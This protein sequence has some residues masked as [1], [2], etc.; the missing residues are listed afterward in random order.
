MMHECDQPLFLR[1][2]SDETFLPVATGFAERVGAALGLAHGEG[3]ALRLATEEIFAHLCQAVSSADCIEMIGSGGGYF[4]ELAFVFRGR[5]P[6]RAFNL[7]ATVCLDDECGLEEMGLLLASRSVDRFQV[8]K[9]AQGR[10]QL[11]LVKE[12][13]YPPAPAEPLPPLAASASYCLREP[14]G[15]TLKLFSRRVLERYPDQLLPDFFSYPGK[16]VDMVIRGDFQALLAIDDKAQVVG[17]ITWHRATPR[18]IEFFGPYDFAARSFPALKEDLLEAFLMAVGKSDAVGV[19]CRLPAESIPETHFER[20]G[21]LDLYGAERRHGAVPVFFRQIQED[22][23]TAVWAHPDLE[24]FLIA[25]YGRLFLPRRIEPVR[26]MGEAMEKNSVFS[27]RMDRSQQLV[28]LRAI[29]LG[30]DL[31]ENLRDHVRLVRREAFNNL[32]FELDLGVPWQAH[33]VPALLGNGFV[34]RLVVPY[35]G[36]SDLVIYQWNGGEDE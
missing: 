32:F 30:A 15:E 14:A 11:S 3:L 10:I 9:E 7:T 17:G 1:V 33:L 28:M 26:A 27:A 16:V 6:L 19:Y 5:I 31:E 24:Q 34:P 25:A 2:P 4:V 13:A 8:R 35:G 21:S 29:Q 36:E 23:G 18:L 12:K 22:P 20:L